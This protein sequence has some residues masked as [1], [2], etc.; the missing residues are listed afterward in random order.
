MT[1][2]IYYGNLRNYYHPIYHTATHVSH[3]KVLN[4]IEASPKNKENNFFV[5]IK[6]CL[7][8]STEREKRT[9]EI[10]IPNFNSLF[11]LNHFRATWSQGL[12]IREFNMDTNGDDPHNISGAGNSSLLATLTGALQHSATLDPDL[13]QALFDQSKT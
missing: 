12:L 11:S 2:I 1:L 13:M 8:S 4:S 6:L 7:F 3:G 9:K 10:F 5:L